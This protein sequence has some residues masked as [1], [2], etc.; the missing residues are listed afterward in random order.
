MFS[1]R[2]LLMEPNTLWK[3][4]NTMMPVKVCEMYSH[5]LQNTVIRPIGSSLNV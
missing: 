5:S 2:I 4:V 1:L 3:K